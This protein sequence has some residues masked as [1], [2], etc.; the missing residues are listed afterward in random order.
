[1]NLEIIDD[2]FFFCE[3]KLSQK[4]IEDIL[5]GKFSMA[6]LIKRNGD[7]PG[8]IGDIVL[9][10][11]YGNLRKPPG[12]PNSPCDQLTVRFINDDIDENTDEIKKENNLVES[13]PTPLYIAIAFDAFKT[14][15]VMELSDLYPGQVMMYGFFTSDKPLEAT[16]ISKTVEE[17]DARTT[18]TTYFSEEKIVIQLAKTIEDCLIAFIELG[19]TYMSSDVEQGEI[20]CKYFFPDGYNV[21]KEVIQEVKK[22]FKKKGRGKAAAIN[23][24]ETTSTATSDLVKEQDE[25]DHEE[26]EEIN[27]EDEKN[28]CELLNEEVIS[29]EHSARDADKATSPLSDYKIEE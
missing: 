18:P 3:E 26:L 8:D 28:E 2:I 25:L 29:G 14:R 22:K 10:I 20:D 15:E 19:P 11:V 21:P 5:N 27:S 23:Q 16:L 4:T 6:L 17:F 7:L 9:Q 24:E 1:M 13:E 12:S